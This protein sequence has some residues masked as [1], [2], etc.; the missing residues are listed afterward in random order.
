MLGFATPSLINKKRV[1][2]P[3]DYFPL[4]MWLLLNLLLAVGAGLHQLWLAVAVIAVG[5]VVV[6]VFAIKGVRW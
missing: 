1:K 3:A 6:A 2:S 4:V 5:S